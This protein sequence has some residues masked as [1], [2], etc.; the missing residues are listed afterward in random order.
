MS[1][2]TPIRNIIAGVKPADIV[3]LP[4]DA[5]VSTNS[6]TPVLVKEIL[7]LVDGKWRI[8]FD[9][10]T[11]AVGIAAIGRIYR[12]GEPY[13]TERITLNT[14]WT[15]FTEDL[16]FHRGDYIQLYLYCGASGGLA[17]ARNFRLCGIYVQPPCEITV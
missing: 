12:N 14:Y 4:H 17:K 16:I 1:I 8:T 6:T 15:T 13:G 5:E 10:K 2:Y 3:K 7:N 11:E 9:L